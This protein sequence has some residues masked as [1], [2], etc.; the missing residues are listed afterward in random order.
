[1]LKKI[2]VLSYSIL[3]FFYNTSCNQEELNDSAS[4]EIIKDIDG[5]EYHTVTIGNQ[6]W[7]V[8][9][10][11]VSRYNNGDSIHNITELSKWCNFTDGACCNYNN[12]SSYNDIYGKL[13]N[14]Y[15]VHD[16][17]KIAPIGFHVASRIDYSQ[18][19][20]YLGGC[21]GDGGN[22]LKEYGSEHWQFVHYSTTGNN[23]SGFNARPGGF[24]AI[25]DTLAKFSSLGIQGRWWINDTEIDSIFQCMLLSNNSLHAKCI[26]S[27]PQ[28]GLSVR[29]VLNRTN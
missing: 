4:S 8:E 28:Y 29:C 19:F 15:A 22:Q 3:F 11:R 7:L 9:N 12:D 21:Y 2:L 20:E 13:Y 24:L 17:R 23:K 18:L 1:M 27:N 10:L 25:Q 6:V 14:W 16:N 5:N 26:E